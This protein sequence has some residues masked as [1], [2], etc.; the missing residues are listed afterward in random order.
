MHGL[1]SL[2]P[3]P[4]YAKV[5]S[6]WEELERDFGLS[7]IKVTP[8]PHFSWQI[9]EDYDFE[10]LEVIVKKVA[11]E[12][13]P[14]VVRTTGLALFTGE[15]PVIYVPVVKTTELLEFHT[16]VWERTEKASI[17]RS[18]YY[19][20]EAWMPHISLAYEDVSRDNIGRVMERLAFQTFDWEMAVDNIALIYEPAGEVGQL[21]YRFAFKV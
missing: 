4:F 14:F 7:G 9:A 15:T 2:L 5:E 17:G 10:R 3:A 19:A 21:E 20:P 8:Y 16:V 12:A 1:V 11:Q 13:T 18:V 6:L